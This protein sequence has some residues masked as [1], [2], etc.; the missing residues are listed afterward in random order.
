[1]RCPICGYPCSYDYYYDV[2]FCIPCDWDETEDDDLY[3]F[4]CAASPAPR[5]TLPREMNIP[6]RRSFATIRA[7]HMGFGAAIVRRSRLV[8]GQRT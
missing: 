8:Q 1:M 3:D 6:R 7:Y 2:F 4:A 5:A